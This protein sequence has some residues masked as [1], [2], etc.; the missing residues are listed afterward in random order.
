VQA[1]TVR[2]AALSAERE[3]GVMMG[4]YLWEDGIVGGHDG[5][6]DDVQ[7][8]TVAG[9]QHAHVV[10]VLDHGEPRVV[11]VLHVGRQHGVPQQIHSV[12]D[13][14]RGSHDLDN[15]HKPAMKLCSYD[16]SCSD[17]VGVSMSSGMSSPPGT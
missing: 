3:G 17:L 2:A 9:H 15:Q 6:A 11:G 12:Q 8:L 14:R 1:H 4:N 13:D 5:A 16:L 10:G 7:A